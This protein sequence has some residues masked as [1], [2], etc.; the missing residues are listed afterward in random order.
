[1][2]RVQ[3]EREAQ[4]NEVLSRAT[5]EPSVLGEVRGRVGDVLHK[6][7]EEARHLHSEIARIQ[8]FQD[9]LNI[10]IAEKMKEYGLSVNELGFV[11]VSGSKTK[12]GETTNKVGVAGIDFSTQLA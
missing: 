5:L 6:K 1:M 3:E 10:S 8:A 11:P 7:N 4:L 2:Q 12:N 9:H